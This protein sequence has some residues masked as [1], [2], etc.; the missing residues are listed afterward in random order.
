MSSG[1]RLRRITDSLVVRAPVNS[2]HGQSRSFERARLLIGCFYA[3]LLVQS[4]MTFN[5]WQGW[6]ATGDIDPL[7]PVRWLILLSAPGEGI[8]AI[9]LFFLLTSLLA[10]IWPERRSAR[11]LAFLSVF[12]FDAMRNS[13]GKIGHSYHLVVLVALVLIFLPHIPRHRELPSRLTRHVYLTVF[14]GCQAIILLT[15]TMAGLTKILGG[16][17]QML[18]GQ[19]HAFH[20]L[21][22]SSLIADRLIETNSTSLLGPLLIEHVLLAW[23]L[24]LGAIYLEVC[25]ILILARPILHRFWAVCLIGLHLAIMLSMTIT[26]ERNI[27]LLALFFLLSPFAPRHIRWRELLAALPG[28][29]L[30]GRRGDH[31]GALEPGTAV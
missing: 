10:A 23:P 3:L 31:R 24:Y 15:Y 30:L 12:L 28:I 29:H 13:F 7:W 4:V 16:L 21:A 14:T 17:A 18:A 22:L 20:P 6:I 9:L 8:R 2:F 25:S 26:F 19:V 27:L 11:A 1:Q 5:Q